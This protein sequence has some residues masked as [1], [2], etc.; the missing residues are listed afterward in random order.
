MLSLLVGLAGLANQVVIA[1]VFGAGAELDG[2]LLAASLPLLAVG[3]SNV[4]LT[5]CF[6]PVLVAARSGGPEYRQLNTAFLLAGIGVA[7]VWSA[8]CGWA[9]PLAMRGLAGHLPEAQRAAT[10]EMSRICWAGFGGLFVCACLS[11]LHHAAKSFVTPAL[12]ALLPALSTIVACLAGP[13]R[14]GP[15]LMALGMLSGAALALPVLL[16][17]VARDLV[18]RWPAWSN[19]LSLARA[20]ANLP[21]VAAAS[22]AY[23][24]IGT[25]DALVAARLGTGVL[26]FLGYSQ[27]ILIAVGN[28]VVL[29]PAHMLIP[30]ISEALAVREPHRAKEYARR[31]LLLV[32]LVSAPV[33]LTVGLLRFPIL[34]V[35]LQRGAFDASMT[36]GV[37]ATLP[38]MLTGMVAMLGCAVA[39]RIFHAHR[40][41]RT[42]ALL[43][44]TVVMLYASFSLLLREVWALQGICLAYALAWWVTLGLAVA[45]LR[46]GR[47]LSGVFGPAEATRYATCL[48]A[49]GLAVWALRGALIVP[50]REAGWWTLTGRLSLTTLLAVLGFAWL[51]TRLLRVHELRLLFTHLAW[52]AHRQPAPR[53]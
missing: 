6:L 40:D 36:A 44:A 25:V 5:S 22:L 29:G 9:A 1:R 51:S 18:P 11:V 7:A 34:E 41:N 2:Y 53:T 27:R 42:P 8:L 31:S 3:V 26:S 43:G 19:F 38:W 13:R 37:A 14:W 47:A 32:V 39:F 50:L 23:T 20:S 17:G 33:A 52:L 30:Y 24:A 16:R 45:A 35:A 21:L 4:S 49:T 46:R 28:L 10:V 48:A 12:A 15:L